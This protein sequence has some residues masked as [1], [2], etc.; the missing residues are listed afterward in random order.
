M[1]NSTTGKK[2]SQKKREQLFHNLDRSYRTNE[3]RK[4]LQRQ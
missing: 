1:W 4:D 3:T 2:Q